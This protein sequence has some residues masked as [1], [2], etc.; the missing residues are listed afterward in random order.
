MRKRVSGDRV[1]P[2]E[3]ELARRWQA[4]STG[5]PLHTI[6]GT[7]VHVQYPGR[8]NHNAGP[9][10]VDAVLETPEGEVR[11]AVELHRQTGDWERHGHGADP[12]YT[13]VVLHVVGR[14]DGQQSRLPGGGHLP[15]LELDVG[16]ADPSSQ[17]RAFPCARAIVAGANPLPALEQAGRRR[18]EAAVTRWRA[19]L[20]G[21]AAE[22]VEQA[23]WQGV[24]EALGY[25]HNE[26]PMRRLT[27]ALPL[28][29]LQARATAARGASLVEALALGKAS[30]LPSQ[31]HLRAARRRDAYAQVLERTWREQQAQPAV[32]AYAWELG[33]VRPENAPVRRVVALAQL[34]LRWP[35]EGMV[36]AVRRALLFQHDTG[37]RGAAGR[38]LAELVALP[39]LPGYWA[40]H[41]DF[42]VPIRRGDG[43]E[44]LALIGSARAADVVVNVLLPLAAAIGAVR[45]DQPLAAAARRVY[46]TYPLLTEN[47]ITRVVR[48]RAGLPG[49]RDDGVKGACAQQGLLHVFETVC[50][51]LR[52][53]ECALGSQG[54]RALTDRQ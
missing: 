12:R 17:E 24:A 34:S 35:G 28:A 54:E 32:R 4:V 5:Q 11:G 53:G 46:D 31:R 33:R 51:D 20:E 2:A 3:R 25:S 23:V 41:W 8:P 52:C 39:C 26:A 38:R 49:G 29:E 22:T 6:D 7:P 15:L 36:A 47:W 42:G 14:H 50:R 10:F 9:D 19:Q 16:A 44:A 48:E 37:N 18:F 21:K 43:A 40:G 45:A 1:V 27:E 30:L 13:G